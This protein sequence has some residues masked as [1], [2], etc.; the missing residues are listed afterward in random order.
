MPDRD[1]NEL[2]TSFHGS[3]GIHVNRDAPSISIFQKETEISGALTS[4]NTFVSRK[5][6]NG[7][8]LS[9]RPAGEI[10][11]TFIPLEASCLF[12]GPVTC[13]KQ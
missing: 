8:T 2:K 7:T 1:Q 5:P 4:M 9:A 13:P 11:L 6:R 12:E 10:A 3:L